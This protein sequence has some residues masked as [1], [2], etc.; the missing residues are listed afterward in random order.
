MWIQNSA[1]EVHGPAAIADFYQQGIGSLC[2]VQD[3][4]LLVVFAGA[5]YGLAVA[6]GVQSVITTQKTKDSTCARSVD[7]SMQVDDAVVGFLEDL[8]KVVGGIVR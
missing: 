1:V 8:P 7:A 6:P 3:D 5:G 2:K 4:P